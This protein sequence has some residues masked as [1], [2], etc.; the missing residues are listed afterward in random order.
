MAKLISLE[1]CLKD[2]PAFRRDLRKAEHDMDTLSASLEAVVGNCSMMVKKGQSFGASV[3]SFLASLREVSRHDVFKEDEVVVGSLQRM[4][5]V[6]G[7][8]ESLRALVVEQAN[9]SVAD[10]LVNFLKTDVKD[11]RETGKVF[12]KLSD[13]LDSCRERYSQV[14]KGQKLEDMKN[15]LIAV[16]SGFSHTSMDYVYQINNLKMKQ[17]T[18]ILEQ[19]LAF[20]YAQM[21]YFMQ[22]CDM[23]KDLEPFMRELSMQL[24]DF[25]TH[26]RA[27]QRLMEERHAVVQEHKRSSSSTSI[28]PVTEGYLFKRGHNALKTWQFRYFKIQNGG[29]MYAARSKD[30]MKPFIGDLRICNIKS[31]PSEPVDRQFAFELTTPYITHVLQAESPAQRDAWVL[32]LQQAIEEALK[33]PE[34]SRTPTS[35]E[36]PQEDDD[37]RLLQRDI[38]GLPGNELCA[39]CRAPNPQWASINFGITLCLGCSGLHRGFC[40]HVSKVR[41]LGMDEMEPEVSQ[42]MLD[43][44]NSKVNEILEACAPPDQ[45]PNASTPVPVKQAWLTSK[46]VERKFVANRDTPK[47]TANAG[48]LE[49]VRSGSCVQVLKGVAMGADVNCRTET[50]VPALA[51]AAQLGNVSIAELLMLNGARLDAADSHGRTPL[52]HAVLRSQTAMACAFLKHDVDIAARDHDGKDALAMAVETTQADIVTLLR[53][54]AMQ[55]KSELQEDKS[56]W[57]RDF[58]PQPS[59]AGSSGAAIV[60]KS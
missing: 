39:D 5:E 22:G 6:L 17:R 53:L 44:G 15:L 9:R 12:S 2:S 40:S 28:T 31:M 19:L 7:E 43:L 11:V 60:E 16:Q 30:E 18:A 8:L 46:Y 47:E 34:P 52:M 10:A 25:A 57:L 26:A 38:A 36:P 1:E 33:I 56:E 50:G 23:M 13:E 41:S 45:H 58:R 37:A 54:A 14:P 27:E 55:E 59:G 3:Q 51:Y 42:V 4:I 20:L 32:A 29:L 24:T 48:L 35:R 21:S 49:G